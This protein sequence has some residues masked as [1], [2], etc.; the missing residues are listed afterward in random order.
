MD[1]VRAR[2]WKCLKNDPV[3]GIKK[4]VMVIHEKFGNLWKIQAY[5]ILGLNM[6]VANFRSSCCSLETK[7]K[8]KYESVSE[9]LPRRS[10]KNVRETKPS[11][12]LKQ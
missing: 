10:F 7:A 3:C 2:I 9:R 5:H 6:W 8:K 12:G 4:H 1:S 11:L